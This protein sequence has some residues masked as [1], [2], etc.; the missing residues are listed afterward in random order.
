MTTVVESCR[1]KIIYNEKIGREKVMKE[2]TR[3]IEWIQGREI[4]HPKGDGW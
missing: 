4:G 3:A 2:K 1:R